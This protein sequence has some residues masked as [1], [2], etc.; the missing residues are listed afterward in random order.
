VH[1]A[2]NISFA[3]EQ[4]DL[5]FYLNKCTLLLTIT[6]QLTQTHILSPCVSLNHTLSY[7]NNRELQ[8]S[9]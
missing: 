6:S 7:A 2:C 8:T 4:Q 3:E 9:D 1:A 5:P